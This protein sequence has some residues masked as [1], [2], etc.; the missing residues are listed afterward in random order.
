MPSS[1]NCWQPCA[2]AGHRKNTIFGPRC[3]EIALVGNPDTAWQAPIR[4]VQRTT[5]RPAAQY[6]SASM[7][8]MTRSVTK[9]SVGSGVAVTGGKHAAAF[10]PLDV[11]DDK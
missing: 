5:R 11:T 7:I 2:V 8:V 3:R 6:S 9:G 4:S 1:W 10:H